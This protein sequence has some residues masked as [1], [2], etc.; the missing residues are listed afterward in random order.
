MYM[1][2]TLMPPQIVQTSGRRHVA[3]SSRRPHTTISGFGKTEHKKR[4]FD[5][6][7]K[8]LS[9]IMKRNTKEIGRI[10]I[11]L[12]WVCFIEYDYANSKEC[13]ASN[14]LKYHKGPIARE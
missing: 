4:F 6:I 8:Q 3:T 11:V 10:W 13:W 12:L 5:E 7:V 1:S 14:E 2:E 9:V